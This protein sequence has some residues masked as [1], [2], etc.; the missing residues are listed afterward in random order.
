MPAGIR[1][2]LERFLPALVRRIKS[3]VRVPERFGEM[4]HDLG[5]MIERVCERLRIRP[6]AVPE[7][8]VIGSDQMIAIRQSS[9]ERLEHARR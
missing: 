1:R 9:E 6:V 5:V 4:I 3:V 8:R 7:T 2:P